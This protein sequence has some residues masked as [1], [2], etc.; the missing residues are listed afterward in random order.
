MQLRTAQIVFVFLLPSILWAQKI[1]NTVSYRDMNDTSYFRFHYDNDYFAAND[2]QYTQGYMFELAAPFL[3]KNPVNHLF[4][5]PQHASNI[6][7]LA[8]EHIGFTPDDYVS[9]EIQQGDRPFAAAIMLKSFSIAIDSVTQSRWSQSLS[10][11]VIGPGAFGKEMQVEIHE[12]TGNKTP[13]GW[14]NQIKNDLVLNYRVDHEYP[15]FNLRDIFDIRSNAS[16]QLG[17]LFTKASIGAHTTLGL[18][19]KPSPSE[20]HRKKFKLYLYAQPIFSAVAYDATLQGG[21]FNRKSPYTISLK[22]VERFTA[23][24][25]YGLILQTKTLYFEYARSVISKEFES[26]ELAK[27]GGIRIGFTF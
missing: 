13:G 19:G 1:D 27:W 15:L 4:F 21:V 2:E 17:T 18:L 10:V 7:G 12:L 5:Q 22:N 8:I 3:R 16:I 24:F 9:A 14:N 25:N 6:H 20:E 26:G 11:G 23:Q